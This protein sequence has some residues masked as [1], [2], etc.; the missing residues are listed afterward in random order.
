MTAALARYLSVE[1][2][3]GPVELNFLKGVGKI[4]LTG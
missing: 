4:C 1:K 2:V 3:T